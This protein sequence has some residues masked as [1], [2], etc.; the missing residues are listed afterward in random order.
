MSRMGF[1][2]DATNCIGCHTCEVACKDANNY[3]LGCGFREVESFA[4]GEYPD[5]FMY[6]VSHV[7]A[8]G[9]VAPK[10][11]EVRN[12]DFCARLRELGE[13]PACVAAC[14]MRVIEFGDVDELV[15]KFEG[16]RVATEFPAL[17]ETG[18]LHPGSVYV[19]KDCMLDEDFDS[20]VL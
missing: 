14:P 17:R 2:V 12:C 13:Q 8:A 11:G 20:V 16:Q 9:K 15:K 18:E 4:C 10:T 5:V 1:V 3:L 19:L 7:K 6:H